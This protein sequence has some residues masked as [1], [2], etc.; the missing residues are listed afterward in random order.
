M[1]QVYSHIDVDTFT[2]AWTQVLGQRQR[3]KDLE[4]IRKARIS[5]AAT[6]V[7]NPT[8]L[9]VS[10]DQLTKSLNI[11]NGESTQSKLSSIN[12]DSRWSDSTVSNKSR[13][14]PSR[15]FTARRFIEKNPMSFDPESGAFMDPAVNPRAVASSKRLATNNANPYKQALG[16][17][18][19]LRF[20][21]LLCEIA[22]MREQA[23]R[24]AEAA[25]DPD[26]E[27]DG[28]DILFGAG[29]GRSLMNAQ[30]FLSNNTQKGQQGKDIDALKKLTG[31]VKSTAF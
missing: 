10:A 19:F 24:Q 20:C 8:R 16:E 17:A 1:G 13:L 29:G 2:L 22:Q 23:E 6:I 3:R 7:G 21:A 18:D 11:V 9:S 25:V 26:L 15:P 5:A 30:Q 4:R 12:K 14:R 28:V 31:Q 27:Q